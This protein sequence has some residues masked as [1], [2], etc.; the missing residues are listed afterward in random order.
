MK[1]V[2]IKLIYYL[3]FIHFHSLVSFTG[4]PHSVNMNEISHPNYE[5]AQYYLSLLL[6]Q[7]G[8][9]S[10]LQSLKQ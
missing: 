7:E 1:N 10:R 2:D 8:D 9:T 4:D 3:F 6:I 5:I